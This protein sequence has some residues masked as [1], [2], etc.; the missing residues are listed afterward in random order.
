MSRLYLVGM[1]IVAFLTA[2]AG[3]AYS[4]KSGLDTAYAH[5]QSDGRAEIRAQVQQS[6]RAEQ[7][8]SAELAQQAS[9]KLTRLEE[10]RAHVQAQL[11]HALDVARHSYLA[12]T[13]CFDARI[14][15]VLNQIGRSPASPDHAARPLAARL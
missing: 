15:R 11:D 1:L 4:Y 7:V 13:V 3:L 9:L 5:G 8:A 2:G 6:I 12:N 10:E 14:V